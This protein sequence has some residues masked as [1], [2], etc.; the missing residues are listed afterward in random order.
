MVQEKAF[1]CFCCNDKLA[2]KIIR[3]V[4]RMC[5]AI[6]VKLVEINGNKGKVETGGVIAQVGL[7]FIDE[8]KIGEYLIVH[9]GYALEKI[10]PEE[11]AITLKLFEEIAAE[12][13]KYA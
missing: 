7:N 10:D 9:A 12:G 4:I 2:V 1:R 11:A 8:P 13:M 3:G 5:L 6:P